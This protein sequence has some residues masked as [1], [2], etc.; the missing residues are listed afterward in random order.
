MTRAIRVLGVL[1][2]AVIMGHALLMA[3]D[4]H[5]AGCPDGPHAA[6]AVAVAPGEG[7]VTCLDADAAC[8]LVASGIAPGAA[9]RLLLLPHH[10]LPEPLTIDAE[11]PPAPAGAFPSHP[12]GVRR[13]LL[14]V[15]RI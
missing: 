4:A 5:A 8:N 14:Q 6:H 1:L 13:A 3:S 9:A 12:P 10:A 2:V 7:L 11:R 15:Y